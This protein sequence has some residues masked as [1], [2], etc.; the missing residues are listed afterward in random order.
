MNNWINTCMM[1]LP[2]YIHLRG[3]RCHYRLPFSCMVKET[4]T[5]LMSSHV[6]VN[7]THIRNFWRSGAHMKTRNIL[8]ESESP[9]KK[10]WCSRRDNSCWSEPKSPGSEGCLKVNDLAK[11]LLFFMESRY[12]I[13]SL[14][15]K[16][17][18]VVWMSTTTWDLLNLPGN[19]NEV[20]THCSDLLWLNYVLLY[21]EIPQVEILQLFW[22]QKQEI[23]LIE[24][25]PNHA[26]S[27]SDQRFTTEG[28][29]LMHGKSL[30][31]PRQ[32]RRPGSSASAVGADV[33]GIHIL[34]A[35][36]QTNK[37][38]GETHLFHLF[39]NLFGHACPSLGNPFRI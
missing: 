1:Y 5:V 22:W 3:Y 9:S 35:E 21:T 8:Q 17:Q 15:Q 25:C 12:Q 18:L 31:M 7:W 29:W 11:L 13:D 32:R 34:G 27:W 14:L 20:E 16:M 6:D 39:M 36:F 26:D 30:D 38:H 2:G 28:Q 23:N 19:L 37:N 10:N 33:H 24:M 4:S